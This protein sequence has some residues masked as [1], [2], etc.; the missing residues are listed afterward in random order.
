MFLL[1]STTTITF[2]WSRYSQQRSQVQQQC[3]QQ[4]M[5][6][7]F[8][9][10]YMVWK[11]IKLLFR[12]NTNFKDQ[13]ILIHHRVWLGSCGRPDNNTDYVCTSAGYPANYSSTIQYPFAKF[14]IFRLTLSLPISAF[15]VARRY[16]R[17]PPTP[18]LLHGS[19]LDGFNSLVFGLVSPLRFECFSGRKRWY[20]SL[21]RHCGTI[22]F[23][24]WYKRPFIF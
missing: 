4:M 12:K 8:F 18:T 21:R 23:A 22:I 9:S 7:P 1:S 24:F 5:A 17:W 14:S 11:K 3:Q 6:S 2:R 16:T 13:S 19:I 20:K 10:V 15:P